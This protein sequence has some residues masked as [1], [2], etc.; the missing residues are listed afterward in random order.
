MPPTSA[1]VAEVHFI[2][3]YTPEHLLTSSSVLFAPAQIILDASDIKL[4]AEVWSAVCEQIENCRSFNDQ[5][6]DH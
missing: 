1:V 2:S 5:V 3:C 4:S 6:R